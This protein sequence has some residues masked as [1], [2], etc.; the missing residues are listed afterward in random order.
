MPE[1]ADLERDLIRAVA[2]LDQA[3]A[4]FSR[5]ERVQAELSRAPNGNGSNGNG[6]NGHGSNG[7]GSNGH[8]SNGGNGHGRVA[9][10][11]ALTDCAEEGLAAARRVLGELRSSPPRVPRQRV[12]DFRHGDP[13]E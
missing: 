9:G 5:Y 8:G 1:P 6:G 4:F 11:S 7:H 13:G 3:V 2:A 12:G 10:G